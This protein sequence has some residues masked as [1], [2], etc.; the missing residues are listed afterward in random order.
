MKMEGAD[1]PL[2]GI[3][4]PGQ[5][6]ILTAVLTEYYRRHSIEEESERNDAAQRAIAL[7]DLG[8]RSPNDLLQ[9]LERD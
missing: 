6:D 9:R 7:Y 2:K 4:D 1:M 3:L 8:Y 5:L